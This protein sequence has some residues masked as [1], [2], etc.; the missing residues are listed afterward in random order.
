MGS[1]KWPG[2]RWG[3]YIFPAFC[4]Y[5]FLMSFLLFLLH[6][7]IVLGMYKWSFLQ[8]SIH[9]YSVPDIVLGG[10]RNSNESESI[11]SF[12]I[13]FLHLTC[14]YCVLSTC[15]AL[16]SLLSRCTILFNPQ[17]TPWRRLVMLWDE[18]DTGAH[19]TCP[20]L[21]VNKCLA[22]IWTQADSLFWEKNQCQYSM[23]VHT[24]K[25]SH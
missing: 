13:L 22:G 9:A 15:L 10:W 2:P 7:N 24:W 25:V 12:F 8:T 20:S 4:L 6:F 5:P 21:T 16:Y 18:P 3:T 23:R 1:N 17:K 19:I 11:F 14:S